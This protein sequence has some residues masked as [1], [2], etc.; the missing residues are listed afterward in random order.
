MKLAICDD[1]ETVADSI[2]KIIQ[3]EELH[4]EIYRYN[5]G[6]DLVEACKGT[7]FFDLIFL[8]IYMADTNGMET[9]KILREMGNRSA[10]VFLTS[11]SDFAVQS[12]EVEA[13]SYLLK[14]IV[15]SKI[16]KVL[17]KFQENYSP[18]QIQFGKKVFE[19]RD[20]LYLESVNKKVHLHCKNGED[21]EWT[22]K[23]DDVEEEKI[24]PNFLR[25][26]RSYIINMDEIEEV[27]SGAFVLSTG[28]EIP[29]RRQNR[30]EIIQE[31][32]HYLTKE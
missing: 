16:Q 1:D 22:S 29:I 18:K 27:K 4:W 8:D 3:N 24:Q 5:T 2:E 25:C 23:L 13:L 15:D 7:R 20:V 6:K 28:I 21:Y 19:M 17:K 9:A 12:Y 30:R 14:P 32:Y 26:H 31:Y 11:T 10:I